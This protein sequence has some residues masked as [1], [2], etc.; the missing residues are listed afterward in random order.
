[1]PI[2]GRYLLIADYYRYLMRTN[3]P[4]F[5]A[6]F[7]RESPLF[8]WLAARLW[9]LLPFLALAALWPFYA[10]GLPRSYD[11]ALH[12]LRSATLE[13]H[14]RQGMLYP[15]WTPEL[16][17]GH[18]YPVF[19]FY[20]PAT[21]YLVVLLH[22]V[23]L[24]LSAAFMG[25]FAVQVLVAGLGMYWY[26]A[27]LFG[28]QKRWAT[29]VAA[30][31]YLYSPY[32]LTNVFIRGALAE[33]GAQALLPWIFWTGRRLLGGLPGQA[34]PQRHLLPFA[35]CLAGLALTHNI[36]LLFVPP[37]LLGFLLLQ[38]W[39][40]GQ[41][42][43]GLSRVF[44]GTLLG[45]G[46]SAFF[47]LPLLGER[48]YLT[49]RPYTIAREL[50]LPISVWTWEN[51]LDWSLT[52]TYSFDRPVRL[53]LV[54]T[55]L[56]GV[57]FG[58]VHLGGT[59]A[60]IN[61]LQR[62]VA[63]LRRYGPA[64]GRAAEWWFWG[65]VGLLSSLAIGE[66]ALPLWESNNILTI[67][68]FP[69]RLLSLVSLPL[70]L[71]TGGLLLPVEGRRQPLLAG[72]LIALIMFTQQPRLAWMKIFPAES[73]DLST[74]VFVQTEVDKG[75][76]S[77]G[78][79]NSSVQEFRP[80]WA[81]TTLEL[82][83]M[84][85]RA[86][87]PLSVTL[88]H[89]NAY[90]WQG[91]IT[92]A[93]PTLLRTQGFYFPG[94]QITLTPAEPAVV[95]A[96]A[97]TLPPPSQE[98]FPYPSTNLG[99]LTVDIPA[100]RHQVQIGWVGTGLQNVAGLVTLAT[101]ALL[102]LLLWWL[103]KLRG[104]AWL[105]LLLLLGGLAVR[106]QQPALQPV[107]PPRNP[108][109]EHGLQLLGYRL[110]QRADRLLLYP[111]WYVTAPPPEQLRLRWQLQDQRGQRYATLASLPY[112]N[113][114]RASN[115]PVGTLVDDAY[116][117]LL[118]PDLAPGT[119]ELA[120]QLETDDDLMP[121]PALVVGQWQLTTPLPAQP[122]PT[123]PLLIDFGKLLRLG[124]YDMIIG[125]R[126]LPRA[127]TTP[128]LVS[129]GD[130]LWYRLYWQASGEIDQNY[131]GLIHL[132]DHQGRPLVKQDQLPGPVFHPP[133]LWD[134]YRWQQDTYLLR[135]PADAPS[136]LYWPAIGAY[137]FATVKL[138]PITN[139]L[140]QAEI[141]PDYY[142]LPPVKLINRQPPRPQQ[143]LALRL[144][145][146]GQVTG[147]TLNPDGAAIRAGHPLTV[148]LFYQV[149]QPVATD[150]TRFVH[151]AD[152][153]GAMVAQ[154]DSQPQAGANPTWSW[155]PGEVVVDSVVLPIPVETP[156][157]SY[158]LFFGFYDSQGAGIRL[159]LAQADG[160]PVLDN[161]APFSEIVI[162]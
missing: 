71:F 70:A 123:H 22:W 9:L 158:T 18:G 6:R 14:L 122:Q 62:P 83:M 115:F 82:D 36:T 56:A 65:G 99:L 39:R 25:A 12:L 5:L 86:A 148:T 150:Y 21:Y 45:M 8:S 135:L 16:M 138:L 7:W 149:D 120:V 4:K 121:P 156:P 50:W 131:H 88:T 68:Q 132:L 31:A 58:I 79:G 143:P 153:V 42:R 130:Y 108:V 49:D 113:S 38:W 91:V 147:V 119:Y 47:W 96:A 63:Y 59:L 89:A 151:L 29:L 145:D 15:R 46:I 55:L 3:A 78:E 73:I 109:A 152:A 52:Y 142:R 94:W 10:E 97:S 37:V 20:G 72:L 129:N 116:Q 77:G 111:Y 125:K 64:R 2:A 80:R 24:S 85:V 110:E 23:G 159:P 137:E 81:S 41:P 126:Q 161:R 1:M 127:R 54:Q 51:F 102:T 90:G 106:Y 13:Q 162:H 134:R 26:A 53:G 40:L 95:T 48:P 67:A 124:G 75:A 103:P 141:A 104:L 19:S 61:P 100:G 33:A 105:P 11:G 87:P 136:G 57:G 27:D 93:E 144:A 140:T 43:A 155:Q 157:G 154:F 139:A 69:W 118:P 30:A 66:W 98:G 34:P 17:L 60:T 146:W 92:A 44:V 35:L 76:E 107:L 74:A 112:F 114:Y 133:L 84:T 28:P 160:T 101:L 128:A 32:L 117:L